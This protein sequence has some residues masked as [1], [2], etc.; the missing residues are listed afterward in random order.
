MLHHLQMQ[1]VDEKP[2]LTASAGPVGGNEAA[3]DKG[4][5]EAAENAVDG[6][7]SCQ[8]F[9]FEEV[10][11]PEEEKSADDDEQDDQGTPDKENIGFH[12]MS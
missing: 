8:F 1:V 2:A 10:T 12:L 6:I 4:E 9:A 11:S 5:G 7:K 3:G